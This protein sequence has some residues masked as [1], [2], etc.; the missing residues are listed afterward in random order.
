MN[1]K[2]AFILGRVKRRSLRKAQGGGG[3]EE[4]GED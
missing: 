2:C 3:G 4:E 1:N